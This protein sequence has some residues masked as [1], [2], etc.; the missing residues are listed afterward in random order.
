MNIQEL[1]NGHYRIRQMHKGKTYSITLDHKPSKKEAIQLMAELLDNDVNYASMTFS[2]ACT[3]YL[4]IKSNVLSPSTKRGYNDLTRIVSKRFNS[5]NIN[6]ITQADVQKEIND[7]AFNHSAKSVAN[8]HGFISTVLKQFRPNLQL[9]TKL[10]QRKSDTAGYIPS[11][12]DIQSVLKAS[13]GT[14][15]E[16]GI[17]LSVCG[18]RRSEVCGLAYDDLDSNDILHINKAYVQGENNKWVLRELN[19][20]EAGTRDIQLPHEYAE[21]YRNTTPVNGRM[22]P[23]YPS[24]LNA[25]LSKIEKKLGI[26]HFKLHACRHFY[27]SLLASQGVSEA[28]IM[29][30]GGWKSTG[31]MKRVYRHAMQ[32]D[33]DKAMQDMSKILTQE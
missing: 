24:T 8:L 3:E 5:L 30:L 21:L 14:E 16:L 1:K 31:V 23:Y 2:T 4:K 28:V 17:K 18:L 15:H 9:Y 32:K 26:P 10:P 12:E 27:C 6:T 29:E 13:E 20:S 22:Y 33:K 25:N 11:I 19:K 7:Y